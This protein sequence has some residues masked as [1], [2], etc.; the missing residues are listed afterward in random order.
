MYHFHL[1]YLTCLGDRQLQL[2]KAVERTP[3]S[4][5]IDALE[6]FVAWMIGAEQLLT[7]EKFVIDELEV[8]QHQLSQYL[9][10]STLMCVGFYRV[11]L[12]I[13]QTLP[14]NMSRL[15]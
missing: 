6:S 10:I 7:S 4:S 1:P 5:F 8:M 3:S 14:P 2:T 9:V 15:I 13:V 11:M 12:C